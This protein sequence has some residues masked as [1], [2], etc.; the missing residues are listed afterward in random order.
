MAYTSIDGNPNPSSM[1]LRDS[2]H[3]NGVRFNTSIPGVLTISSVV[4]DDAGN[5]TNTLNNSVNGVQMSISNTV[6]LVVVG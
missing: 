3:L 2:M 6:E 1:W 4:V 5:Y